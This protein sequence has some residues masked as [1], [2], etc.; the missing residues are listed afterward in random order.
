MRS[1]KSLLAASIFLPLLAGCAGGN[2]DPSVTD[3]TAE[4]NALGSDEILGELHYGESASIAYTSTP[5]YRAHFFNGR[6]N[7]WLKIEVTS[8][9]GDVRAFVTDDRFRTIRRG[10]AGVLRKDGKYFIVVRQDDLQPAT[11]TVKL[12]KR[13]PTPSEPAPA[14]TDDE[15]GPALDGED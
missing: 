1:L 3:G 12:A 9:V 4:L 10:T 7:D 5:R 6:K 11:I 14:E 13:T 8:S 2:D 15:L